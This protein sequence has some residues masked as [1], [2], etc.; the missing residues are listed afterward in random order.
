MK[1]NAFILPVLA[2]FLLLSFPPSLPAQQDVKIGVIYPMSGPIAQA[3]LDDRHAIELA[4]E[5][6][7]TDQ[8]QGPEPAPGENRRPPQPGRGQSSASSSPTTRGNRTWA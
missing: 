1:R 2:L 4:L 7:N 8:I 5:I 3:G 6:I